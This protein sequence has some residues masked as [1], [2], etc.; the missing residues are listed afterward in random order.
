MFRK[1]FS[2]SIAFSDLK[3]RVARII[4]K[5][6][7]AY[8]LLTACRYFDKDE[9]R[10]GELCQNFY[11]KVKERIAGSTDL[12]ILSMWLVNTWSFM[13]LLRQYGGAGAV[14]PAE[15]HKENTEIQNNQRVGCDVSSQ[16][17][18]VRHLV[19][20]TYR[21]LMK[22]AV[23]PILEPKIVPGVL[24]HESTDGLMPR[25]KS[26]D[27]KDTKKYLSDLL[28]FMSFIHAKLAVYGADHELLR[29]VFRQ[30][31]N[32]IS[33]LA[34]NQLMFRKDLCTFEKAIQIK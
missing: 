3:P 10:L 25:R 4:T 33:T 28:E 27:G 15:W 31:A 29:H 11:T 9:S 7:P 12:D 34:L 5:N 32:W 20:E 14:W 13:N 22:T 2:F 21:A 16:V 17:E 24:Q 19:D 18:Q 8:L 1:T 26:I 6:F 23:Q 30:M